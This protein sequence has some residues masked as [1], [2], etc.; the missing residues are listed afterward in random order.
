MYELYDTLYI[1]PSDLRTLFY[2]GS[3]T[4]PVQNEMFLEL[5]SLPIHASEI[6]N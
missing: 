3:V 5:K 4:K 1:I 2:V 6:P